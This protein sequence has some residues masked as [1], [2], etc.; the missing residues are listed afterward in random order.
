MVYQGL[1]EVGQIGNKLWLLWLIAAMFGSGVTLASFMKLIH[2]VFLGEKFSAKESGIKE[3]SAPMWIT[4]S[5]L[6]LLC[7]TFG[8]FAYAI[9]LKYLIFPAIGEA[10]FSG[11]WQPGLATLMIFGGII[12]GLIIYLVSNT[13]GFREDSSYV[14]GEILTEETR[15]TGVD[16]YDSVKDMPLLKGIYEKAEQKVFDIY[17]QGR[18]LALCISDKLRECHTGILRT[19]LVW[20]LLGMLVLLIILMRQV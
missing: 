11:I 14:G 19:Y 7:V 12:L 3:V 17:D 1:I 8:V 6:A 2:T 20:C 5:V 13:R 4:T 9:P 15:V 16:F 18:K 10:G